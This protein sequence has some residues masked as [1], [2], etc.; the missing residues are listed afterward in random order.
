MKSEWWLPILV[1]MPVLLAVVA[2]VLRTARALVRF[3]AAGTLAVAALAAV[4]TWR[5]FHAGSLLAAGDWFMLD[6]LS[7]YHIVVMMIAQ[8]VR[9][10]RKFSRAKA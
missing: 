2:L 1:L 8:S 4:V 7:A 9:L 10:K 5:V 6:A 3:C